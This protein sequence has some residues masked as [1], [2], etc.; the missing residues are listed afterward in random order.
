MELAR[1]MAMGGASVMSIAVLVFLWFGETE[2][3]PSEGPWATSL[4]MLA[5]V[6]FNLGAAAMYAGVRA[7]SVRH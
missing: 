5:T 2:P 7:I 4:L 1:I 6:A 3:F